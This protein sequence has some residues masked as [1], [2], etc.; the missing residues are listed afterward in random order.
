MPSSRKF[1]SN[2][3]EMSHL[4]CV[5]T[6]GSCLENSSDFKCCF[7]LEVEAT[8]EPSWPIFAVLLAI[9]RSWSPYSI[10]VSRNCSIT[11]EVEGHFSAELTNFMLFVTHRNIS[12]GYLLRLQT[13]YN[14]AY[15]S[16]RLSRCRERFSWKYRWVK[17]LKNMLNASSD[18][19]STTIRWW[20]FVDNF[21]G[22]SSGVDSVCLTAGYL[23]FW[24]QFSAAGYL[25]LSNNQLEA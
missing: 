19:L 21:C 16:S 6:S 14:F 23:V 4:L 20:G 13:L 25:D 1:T 12:G 17:I 9:A 15:K 2:L 11:P 7:G 8:V 18:N 10:F 3:H 5:K 24:K 22:Y